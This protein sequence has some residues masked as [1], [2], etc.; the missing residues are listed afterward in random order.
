MPN[1][2]PILTPRIF[3]Q[4]TFL[5]LLALVC[6]F[7]N[8]CSVAPTDMTAGDDEYSP[9]AKYFVI[10]SPAHRKEIIMRA[11]DMIGKDYRWGG[12][13]P[14]EGF[15]CSGLVVYVVDQVTQRRLPHHAAT[16]AKMT[17]PI[18]RKELTPGDLVF[19]NTMKRRHSH[20]GIYLGDNRFVHSPTPGQKVRIDSL[21]TAYYSER[22]DGA[23]TF[24]RGPGS[25]N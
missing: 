3:P 17:R 20:V 13:N 11:L 22:L 19:F 21:K 8:S 10:D 6:I 9:Y 16:I 12:S 7:V 24:V 1:S 2:V 18:K 14:R 4:W 15:D 23:R 25:L 5:V